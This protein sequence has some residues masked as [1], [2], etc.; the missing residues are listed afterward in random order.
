M[1]KS[2]FDEPRFQDPQAAR[3]YLEALRWPSGAVCPHCGGAMSRHVA[4]VDPADQ[5]RWWA[6]RSRTLDGRLYAAPVLGEG[7]R[8]PWVRVMKEVRACTACQ[9][10][11][12]PDYP[13][14][15]TCSEEELARLQAQRT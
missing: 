15:Q 3:E 14:E 11:I 10:Y 1:A 4:D 6:K 2:I 13:H 8:R 9:V 7:D 5:G 12:D